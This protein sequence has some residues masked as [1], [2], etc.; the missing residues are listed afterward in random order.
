M[1]DI[2]SD[3]RS[4]FKS[5]VIRSYA[6]IVIIL[7]STALIAFSCSDDDKS[8][9]STGKRNSVS[10]NITFTYDP[11]LELIMGSDYAICCGPWEEGYNEATTL[12]IFFYDPS[13][14][15][16]FWKLFIV[17]DEVTVDSVYTLPS[18]GSLFQLFSVDANTSNELA[19]NTMD[20]S[21]WIK[22]TEFE[23]GPPLRISFAIDTIIGSE[24]GNMP[25]ITVTGDFTCTIYSNPAP[26][27]CDFSM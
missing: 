1:K 9:T 11:A 12:K 8:P 26:F 4:N 22:F 23:C 20:S 2:T 21:G 25:P 6:Q 16:S 27:G 3:L 17:L 18:T 15:E 19:S 24:F 10:N 7:I 13:F 14:N 5:R